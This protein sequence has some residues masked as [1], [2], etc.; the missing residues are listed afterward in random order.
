MIPKEDTNRVKQARIEAWSST[1]AT[2]YDTSKNIE[3][4]KPTIL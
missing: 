2:A 1:A 3:A 4:A